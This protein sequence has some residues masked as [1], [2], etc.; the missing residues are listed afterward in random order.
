[1]V[2]EALRDKGDLSLQAEVFHLQA[3]EK[4]AQK[5]AQ[6]VML[7]HQ[8]YHRQ[9]RINNLAAHQL[10]E[11]NAYGRLYFCVVWEHAQLQARP[12][13]LRREALY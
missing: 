6:E 5:L 3:G 12:K 9:Q 4:K 2:N 10:A 1:M 8:A 7:A 11:A 13:Q